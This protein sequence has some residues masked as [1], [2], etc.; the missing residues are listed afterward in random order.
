MI[1]KFSCQAFAMV[2]ALP[3]L[4]Q[5]PPVVAGKD[6]PKVPGPMAGTPALGDHGPGMGDS[7][8]ERGLRRSARGT[9]Y[10]PCAELPGGEVTVEHRVTQPAGWQAYRVQVAPLETVKARLRGDHEAWFKVKVV[11]KWG[12]LAEGMLQNRIPTGN[13]QASYINARNEARTVFFVVDTT[14]LDVGAEPYQLTFTRE[15]TAA[16]K[17]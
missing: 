2:M 17:P 9:G 1:R 4:A 7:A 11:D 14:N 3:L 15:V 5:T 16:A 6:L 13:P 12:N 8:L 10:V